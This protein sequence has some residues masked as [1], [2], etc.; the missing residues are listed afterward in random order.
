MNQ[1]RGMPCSRQVRT[2]EPDIGTV[3]CGRGGEREYFIASPRLRWW[4]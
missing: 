1:R 3:G 4:A 2:L